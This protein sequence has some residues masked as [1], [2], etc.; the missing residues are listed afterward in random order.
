MHIPWGWIKQR[1]HFIAEGLSKDYDVKIVLRTGYRRTPVKN[2]TN[3]QKV[4]LFKI[5]FDKFGLIFKINTLLYKIQLRLFVKKSDILWFTGPEQ[6][7]FVNIPQTKIVIYDCMDD[8]LEF[9]LKKKHLCR[10]AKSEKMLYSRADIVFAS[11]DYLGQKLKHRYYDREVIVVNNAMKPITNNG[12]NICIELPPSLSY[13]VSS[14]KIKLV[15]IG[16]ISSWLDIGLLV[17]LMETHENIEC[18]LIGPLD[19]V[20]PLNYARLYYIDAINHDCVFPVMENADILVMPFIVNELICSVNP[21]KLYEYV[22][23]GKPCVAPFY[24][25]SMKFSDYVY[26]YENEKDFNMIINDLIAAKFENKMSKKACKQFAEHNT[27]PSR[28]QMMQ[29]VLS[30]L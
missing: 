21:V 1:P 4:Y 8:M 6:M 3:I 30:S 14:Q 24:G 2:E 28:V 18:F 19:N 27:W 13:Y 10:I 16:T 12:A 9:P 17:N 20:K 22:Y 29:K 23:S 11:S 26:L 15:Y 5:P 25:E 7:L